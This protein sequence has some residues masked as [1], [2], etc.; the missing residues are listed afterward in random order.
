M[1]LTKTHNRM[2]EGSSVNIV[3]FGAVGDGSTDDT[4][5]IQAAI[6]YANGEKEVV[7]PSG[8]FIFTEIINKGILRGMGGTLKL[9]D[10]TCIDAS[11][12]Y[13]LIHNFNSGTHT[14]SYSNCQ[15]IDLII[16]GNS[17]NN[18]LFTVADTITASGENIVVSGCNIK[19]SPDSGIMFTFPEKGLCSNNIVSGCRDVGIYINDNETASDNFAA[20]TIDNILMNCGLGGIAIKRSLRGHKVSG[21]YIYSCGNGITH[22]FFGTGLGG[23]P[24]ECTISDNYIFSC[25]YPQRAFSPVET[26]IYLGKFDNG[27]CVNNFIYDCSGIGIRSDGANYVIANNKV[28]S[29]SLVNASPTALNN[30]GIVVE[31]RAGFSD[32]T[33]VINDNDV[34]GFR[35]FALSIGSGKITINGGRYQSTD[36]GL[37]VASSSDKVYINDSYFKATSGTDYGVLLGALASNIVLNNVVSDG[38][39]GGSGFAYGNTIGATYFYKNC[40]DLVSGIYDMNLSSGMPKS[41]N[42]GTLAITGASSAVI[43]HGLRLGPNRFS[44]VPTTNSYWWVSAIDSTTFTINTASSGNYTVYWEAEV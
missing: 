1:A 12:L 10:N 42:S 44:I 32:S 33:C 5:A 6:N 7:I 31:N 30:R 36:N 11:V 15:Y 39:G 29:S 20:M 2:I 40:V 24:Q 34:Q 43:T 35:D 18:T 41:R 21:N 23:W 17:A 14:T 26:G 3:D 25:G 27:F 13:Y 16:D 38:E 9:K 37:N 19:N 22:E 28:N 4:L 8:T